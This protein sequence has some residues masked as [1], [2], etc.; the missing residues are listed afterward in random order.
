M[1]MIYCGHLMLVAV[2]LVVL[3]PGLDRL[4]MRRIGTAGKRRPPVTSGYY[5]RDRVTRRIAIPE[6]SVFQ[7]GERFAARNC[8]TRA[9]RDIVIT[10]ASIT[11]SSIIQSSPRPLL[12]LRRPQ[13]SLVSAGTDRQT[14]REAVNPLKGRDVSWLHLAIQ[15]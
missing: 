6:D 11:A 7:F 2:Q 9:V 13:I 8:D 1:S 5:V 10:L 12:E 14:A 3:I 15:V 4:R